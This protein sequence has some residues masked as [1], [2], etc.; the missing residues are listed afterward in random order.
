MYLMML[1][2]HIEL[3][4]KHIPHKKTQKKLA[5]KIGNNDILKMC[6]NHMLLSENLLNPNVSFIQ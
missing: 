3:D 4:F 6:I 2:I 5:K 1:L